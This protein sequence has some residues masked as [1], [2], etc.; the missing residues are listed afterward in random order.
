MV[1]LGLAD[2][3]WY[4]LERIQDQPA[5]CKTNSKT[6]LI[7]GFV[8]GSWAPVEVQISTEAQQKVGMLGGL[9]FNCSNFL[10]HLQ[11][12]KLLSSDSD[13]KAVENGPVIYLP[14]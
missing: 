9:A 4:Q 12:Q 3:T 7:A 2:S 6:C 13:S 8:R 5:V 1:G 10:G 11:N 14:R